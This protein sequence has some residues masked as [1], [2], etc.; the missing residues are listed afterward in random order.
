MG[1]EHSW[2]SNL[3]VPEAKVLFFTSTRLQMSGK[4]KSWVLG[5]NQR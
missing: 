2:D 4:I 5:D 3:M 1:S